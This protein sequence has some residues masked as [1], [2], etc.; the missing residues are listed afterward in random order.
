[1]ARRSKETPSPGDLQLAI[2]E[3]LWEAGELPAAAVH[4]AVARR[5]DL[6]LTTVATVLQRMDRAGIVTHRLEGRV[7]VYR[8][9]VTQQQ[10]RRQGTTSLIRRFFDGDPAAL[11]SH[12][13]ET[14]ALSA[15]D[16][17]RIRRLI[18]SRTP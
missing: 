2:L 16:I 11:V 7:H 15:E 6:A 5:R 8:A 18:R 1:M 14:D 4:A 13:V 10:L 3:V 17:A 12:L 9:A